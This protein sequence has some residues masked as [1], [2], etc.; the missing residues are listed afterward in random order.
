[1]KKFISF[2]SFIAASALSLAFAFSIITVAHVHADTSASQSPTVS[3]YSWTGASA[4]GTST[5]SINDTVGWYAQVIN[6]TTTNNTYT[7]Y[8]LNNS[9]GV[10]DTHHYTQGN[11]KE[12]TS[13]STAGLKSMYVAAIDTNGKNTG[14]ESCPLVNVLPI[15]IS[16]CA[17]SPATAT[18]GANVV[19]NSSVSG[20]K[21]PYS[22]R[23]YNPAT[24]VVDTHSSINGT[25]YSNTVS[26]DSDTVSY[27]ATGTK[28]MGIDVTSSAGESTGWKWCSSPVTVTANTAQPTV[29][30][31]YP[32]A[33][34]TFTVGSP[35]QLGFSSSNALATFD[36]QLGGKAYGHDY[37]NVNAPES[38][39]KLNFTI[40]SDALPSNYTTL[41]GYQFEIYYNGSLI[42]YSP[43]FTINSSILSQSSSTVPTASCTPSASSITTG[44]SVTWNGTVSGGTAPYN[45]YWNNN[46]SGVTDTHASIGGTTNSESASYASAGSKYMGI[47]VIDAKG[48][49]SGWKWCSSPVTVTAVTPTNPVTAGPTVTCV[50]WSDPTVNIGQTAGWAAQVYNGTSSLYYTFY[51][52]NNSTGVTDTHHNTHGNDNDFMS[53]STA[54]SKSM[55]VAAIDQNGVNTGWKA[56]PSIT[57][58]GGQTNTSTNTN[59]SVSASQTNT[60]SNTSA[61]TTVTGSSGNT[62]SASAGQTTTVNSSNSSNSSSQNTGSTQTTAVTTPA[63]TAPTVSCTPSSSSA[64]IGSNV[65]WNGTVSGGTAPY[66]FYWSNNATGV[67]DTHASITGTTDSDATSY[68]AT[69]SKYMGIAVIDSKGQNTGWKWCSSPVTVAT[70][71]TDNF[72]GAILNAWNSIKSLF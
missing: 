59:T 63:V 49:G 37:G 65:T 19:W 57:V 4:I 56:C 21:A 13:F 71:Y 40:P 6:G 72:T 66:T 58:T 28:Y 52:L 20:G 25:F 69:G 7:F 30:V 17:P 50:V 31:Y 26:S 10:T 2:S 64:S 16:S 34:S 9:T 47:A 42:A 39:A 5:A 46:D 29:N 70:V 41:S 22:Y 53:F 3:C 33:N 8:W 68:S 43:S 18:V 32:T 61:N 60:S 45:F 36:V 55:Y 67:T 14:W 62:A 48:Q 44:S 24:G 1:M 12:F 35:I 51:W 15:S 11:D 23:W 27:N 54:G 38:G